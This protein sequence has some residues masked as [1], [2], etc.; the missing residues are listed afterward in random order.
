MTARPL[1]CSQAAFEQRYRESADPWNFKSSEY[2]RDRYD[3]TMAMLTRQS[4]RRAFEPGCSVG[5]LTARLASRCETLVATD[6]SPSAVARARR[7]CEAWPNVDVYRADLAERLPAGR[8][9]LIVFSEVGYYFDRVDLIRI[10]FGLVD[11][12]DI[13]GEFV[14][15]HW[16]GH[17]PDHMLHGDEVHRLL[18]RHLPLDWIKGERHTG[19][20]I[21]S[22]R[23]T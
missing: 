4:Y 23:R 10:A 9:D 12:L 17:S 13:G 18:A 3:T 5:E 15:V 6:F 1:A 7:R 14:A 8:F 2:E 22:W 11:K 16:R 19:F 20:C 21:D